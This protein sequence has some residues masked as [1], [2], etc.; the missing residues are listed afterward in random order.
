MGLR[1]RVRALWFWLAIVGITII[2]GGAVAILTCPKWAGGF[3]ANLLSDIAVALLVI[4][5]FDRRAK[6]EEKA[7]MRTKVLAVLDRE[8]KKLHDDTRVWETQLGI[9]GWIPSNPL[10]MGGWRSISSGPL[11]DNVP[12]ELIAK[13][14]DV[15]SM[16]ESTNAFVPWL[17][18]LMF[19]AAAALK[20]A[21]ERQ[22]IV[23]GVMKSR[24]E[25]LLKQLDE[26]IHLL[27]TQ[28]AQT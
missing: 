1:S 7:E 15:D 13:L 10:S 12:T 21:K 18:H 2:L 4:G 25:L 24:C 6:A 23:R 8:L 20:D 22:N 9:P 16:L 11:L 17:L 26:A 28:I 3:W 14:L 19:G 27:G 5:W